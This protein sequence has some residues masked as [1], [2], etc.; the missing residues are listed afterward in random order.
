M[1]L[2]IERQQDMEV[3][4]ACFIPSMLVKE[5]IVVGLLVIL[6]TSSHFAGQITRSD[7]EAE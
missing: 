5:H 6:N 7:H 1:D 3:L 2:V 4:C